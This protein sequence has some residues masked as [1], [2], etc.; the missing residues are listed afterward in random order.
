MIALNS[1]SER[2]ET[3]SLDIPTLEGNYVKLEP[4]QLSHAEG[5]F[6]A[7]NNPEIWKYM[8]MQIGSPTDAEQ[9]VRE[10]LD[11]AEQQTEF[12]YTIFSKKDHKVLG[13]T[14]FFDFLPYH[15]QLEIG[16]TWLTPRVWG[17]PVN[18]ECKYL[19]LKHCFEHLQLLRVQLKTDLRNH[20]AQRSMEKI[21][22]AREGI[23]RK[24]RVL[25]S[26]YVRDTVMYSVIDDEWHHVRAKL[27]HML[28][29][30]H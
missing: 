29:A 16:H 3:M 7:G 11:K 1:I 13:S 28:E 5:W 23:L 20:W 2:V 21:G 6:E 26:G 18:V 9:I 24:H 19:L 4:L 14:R 30:N 15:K 12:T 8:F 22:A 17:S 10:A 27:E 25:P